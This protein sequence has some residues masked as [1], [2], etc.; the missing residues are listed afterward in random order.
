MLVANFVSSIIK[1][2]HHQDAKDDKNLA[3]LLNN[4]YKINKKIYEAF[5][6]LSKK[7]DEAQTNL[8]FKS[9]NPEQ[10][11]NWLRDKLKHRVLKVFSKLQKNTNLEVLAHQILFLNFC[12]RDK[13]VHE[14]FQFLTNTSFYD[15]MFDLLD[16][17]NASSR[18]AEAYKDAVM[19]LEIIKG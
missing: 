7:I 17:T 19:A 4:T 5:D 11:G 10:L 1:V 8:Y 18:E 13:P 15:E 3:K 14:E 9:G 2:F 6:D 12:E 16:Q